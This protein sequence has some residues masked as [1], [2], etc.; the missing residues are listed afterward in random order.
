LGLP[1]F[2][3]VIT[4]GTGF[5]LLSFLFFPVWQRL[6]NK[7]KLWFAISAVTFFSGAILFDIIGIIYLK[8]NGWHKDL[9][10]GVLDTIEESLEMAGLIIFVYSLLL[11][12]QMEFHGGSISISDNKK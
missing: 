10:Y 1:R 7:V 2:T 4:Y 5:V 9:I 6:N 8:M 11:L 12:I 3:W